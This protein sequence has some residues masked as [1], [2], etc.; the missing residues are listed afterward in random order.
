MILLAADPGGTTGW[1]VLDVPL[2]T[3]AYG[4]IRGSIE[5]Q[6]ETLKNLVLHYQPD[7][8][9]LESFR[10]R[11]AKAKVLSWSDMPV[12][13]IMGSMVGFCSENG[14]RLVQQDPSCKQFFRAELLRQ[15]IP[16]TGSI[17][18]DDAARHALYRA[19]FGHKLIHSDEVRKL[20]EEVLVGGRLRNRER[21]RAKTAGTS[22]RSRSKQSGA[23]RG[24]RKP[25]KGA[26][27]RV[28]QSAE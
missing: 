14:Y 12:D 22:K 25:K 17:H 11:P 7:E 28:E 3:V 5:Q 16:M 18:T 15:V 27:V 9:V 19:W 10:L 20:Y 1:F 8:V 4:V 26:P 2:T 21:R 24:K 23:A 13:Q 6:A